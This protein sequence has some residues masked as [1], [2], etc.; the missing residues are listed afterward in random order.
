MNKLLQLGGAV[1][2]TTA[3]AGSVAA[4]A[5]AWHPQGQIIKSVQNINT[6]SPQAD[7]NTAADALSAKPGDILQYTITVK[8]TAAPA[9]KH[10]NDLAFVKVTDTLP[11]GVA[12][13]DTPNTRTVTADLGTILPGK[14]A[15]KTFK[16]KVTAT[17][18]GTIKNQA[19][20]Y[21][22]SAVKDSP[23]TGCDVAYIKV[24]VPEKPAPTPT[25]TPVTPT[26][27]ETPEA[28]T[29]L[30]N[31]GMGFLAPVAGGITA[32][33]GYVANT[34]RLRRRTHKA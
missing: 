13:V 14:S 30:P 1:V 24:T 12:L 8:D 9:D 20:Y 29:E 28:P 26:T 7:A 3:I 32:A 11:A 10:Y 31:T 33:A 4:P 23:K 2:L 19:C 22:D 16:V 27:P 21:G 15:S 5:Y 25:P 6:K 34:L 18:S 17:K